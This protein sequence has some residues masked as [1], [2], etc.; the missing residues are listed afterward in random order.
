MALNK[1]VV[2]VAYTYICRG[3]NNAKKKNHVG[4]SQRKDQS[5]VF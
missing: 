1:V 4:K 3:S 5:E 2:I